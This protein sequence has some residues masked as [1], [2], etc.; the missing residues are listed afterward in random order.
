MYSNLVF[1][2]EKQSK[3]KIG[4]KWQKI[5]KDLKKQQS[6]RSS[7]FLYNK[8]MYNFYRFLTL[9]T[10]KHYWVSIK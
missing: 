7:I 8:K 4:V 6:L 9:F 3:V 5:K 2:A 1:T 10:S